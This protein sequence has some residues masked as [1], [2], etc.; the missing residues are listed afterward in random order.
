MTA[1]MTA[2]TAVRWPPGCDGRDNDRDGTV[3]EGFDADGD[4]R[5]DCLNAPPSA[6]DDS[7][8]SIDGAAVTVA[9]LANDSDP[10]GDALMVIAATQGPYGS[11]VVNGDGT[12]TYT[13]GIPSIARL[14]AQVARFLLNQGQANSLLSKLDAARRSRARGNDTAARNQLAAFI[15]ELEA[16]KRSGRLDPA[17]ADALIAAARALVARGARPAAD[18]FTYTV[19][20][21]H[22][23][24]AT[25][26][27]HITLQ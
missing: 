6:L 27:V 25:A 7:A 3:D 24:T 15:N 2:P 4:G 11:V 10:N 20:D 13:P 16:L 17:T 1:S 12:V 26:R 9:V 23:G 22:G 19:S 8:L 14:M 5:A 21:G 18:R